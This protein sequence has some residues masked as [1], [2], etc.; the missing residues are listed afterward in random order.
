VS[1]CLM[2]TQVV[3][4]SAISHAATLMVLRQYLRKNP[5]LAVF[6]IVVIVLT[7]FLWI[8]FTAPFFNANLGDPTFPLLTVQVI[9]LVLVYVIICIQLWISDDALAARVTLA[10]RPS[11]PQDLECIRKWIGQTSSAESGRKNAWER[12]TQLTSVPFRMLCVKYTESSG[13]RKWAYWALVEVIFPRTFIPTI[14]G[15][16][17]LYGLAVAL[18][19]AISLN[20]WAKEEHEKYF[21]EW[22]F[23]QVIPPCLFLL[24]FL[25]FLE[26]YYGTC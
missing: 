5:I 10:R 22:S 15:C 8:G 24:S 14:L 26:L 19:W 13:W 25:S 20:L 1:T 23:G 3:N 9:G 2:T 12:V 6:R 11:Q 17:W 18:Y 7:L 4:F 21:T 16:L